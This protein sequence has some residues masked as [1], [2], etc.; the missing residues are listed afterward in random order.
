MTRTGLQ[1]IN[2]IGGTGMGIWKKCSDCHK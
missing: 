2:Q 1:A